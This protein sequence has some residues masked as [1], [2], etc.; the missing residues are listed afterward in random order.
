MSDSEPYE[1]QGHLITIKDRT[2]SLD[3]II[4]I[5]PEYFIQYFMP[6]H[7]GP[8]K[9]I[10]RDF[11]KI[12]IKTKH[13]VHSIAYTTEERRD[14]V[15]REL[16]KDWKEYVLSKSNPTQSKEGNIQINVADS[17]NVNIVTGNNVK[18]NSKVKAE[19]LDII[20]QLKQA[21]TEQ[22]DQ[23]SQSAE[24]IECAEEIEEKINADKKVSKFA[25]KG[26][27][28]STSSIAGIGEFVI[29]LGQVLG[30]M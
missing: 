8:M 27:L 21:L 30:L 26:L 20:N 3:D 5:K 18:I 4:S 13:E 23:I 1:I 16:K 25:F 29:S 10:A 24:L 19:A 11:P 17:N 12:I 14:V 22:K 9:E 28:D 15:I 6:A 7:G 2:F